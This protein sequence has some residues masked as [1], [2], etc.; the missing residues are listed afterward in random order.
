MTIAVSFSG[1]PWL[2]A[3]NYIVTQALLLFTN[4]AW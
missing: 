1:E 4:I 3:Y 2:K